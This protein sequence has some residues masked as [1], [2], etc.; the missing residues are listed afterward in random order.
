MTKVFTSLDYAN[1]NGVVQPWH[2][3]GNDIES[4]VLDSFYEHLLGDARIPSELNITV[5]F[6]YEEIAKALETFETDYDIDAETINVMKNYV[7]NHPNT[8]W[9]IE[10]GF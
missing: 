1:L 7:D 3:I 4:H 8:L 5:W 6:T 10:F 9:V 2:L